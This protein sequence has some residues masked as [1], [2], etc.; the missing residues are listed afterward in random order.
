M[1][2]SVDQNQIQR[3]VLDAIHG[4][5]PE[6]ELAT[7]QFE[8]PLRAQIDMDSIDFVRLVIRLH[9]LTGVAI[10]ESDYRHLTTVNTCVEYLEKNLRPVDGK[11][12]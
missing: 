7:I 1:N 12:V 9:E 3:W 2:R 6:I 5:A 4:V 10:P 8:S 11:S